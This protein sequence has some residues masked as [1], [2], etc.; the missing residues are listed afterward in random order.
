MIS[1][2]GSA[3][4]RLD[5]LTALIE[6]HGSVVS[7]NALMA[8]AWPNQVVEENNLE[9]QISALRAAFGAERALIRTVS[10]RGYQFTGEI[11]FPAKPRN[12]RSMPGRKR[13]HQPQTCGNR[14]PN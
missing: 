11:H 9:V 5:V 2:S 12:R 3:A 4:A 1:R 10:R 6:A 7:K 14:F 8:R 13:R